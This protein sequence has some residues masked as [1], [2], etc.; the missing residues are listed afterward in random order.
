MS[1]KTWEV[2]TPEEDLAEA[3]ELLRKHFS[4]EFPYYDA[5]LR[6]CHKDGSTVWVRDR[7]KVTS[8]TADGRPELMFGTHAE[9]T[10]REEA[11]LKAEELL[12][13][14]EDLLQ[15]VDRRT[16]NN[17]NTIRSL[18]SLKAK[19]AEDTTVREALL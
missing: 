5:E 15:E 4:R 13:E 9:V 14:K 8:W 19:E 7:G 10:E 16:K 11:E 1:I 6:M 18:L 3:A 17:M 12:R 2:L